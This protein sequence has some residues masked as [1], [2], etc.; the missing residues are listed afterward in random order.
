VE[1]LIQW[2]P[3]ADG[4]WRP[5]NISRARL[6]G[7]EVEGSL[8]PPAFPVRIDG[9]ASWLDARDETGDRVTGGKQLV[10]RARTTV[11]GEVSW[12][13]ASWT[14]S[15]GGR[16]V[17]RVPVTP[18]NTKWLTGYALWHARAR[19]QIIP[20]LRLEL[21]GRNLFDTRYEDLRGYATPGREILLGLRF[22]QGGASR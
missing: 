3:G 15:A 19:W 20:S 22:R 14:F 17:S 10:G 12:D 8:D 4:V 5:H 18:A 16:G 21:E 13:L 1:D 7:L 2:S 6:A 9:S 11:F